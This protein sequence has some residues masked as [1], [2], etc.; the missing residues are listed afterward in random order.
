MALPEMRTAPIME[1]ATHG[2]SGEPFIDFASA[3]AHATR[4]VPVLP[5]GTRADEALAS[6]VGRRWDC[7]SHLVV[8][9]GERFLGVIPIESLVAAPGHRLLHGLID[10]RPPA[11][12]PGT[13]REVAAWTAMRRGE[14]ALA[15][16]DAEGRFVGLIPP[17]RL[18]AVGAA[19]H[20]EDLSR[21]G[22]FIHGAQDARHANDEPVMRRFRH[23][24][25]WVLV[26]LAGALFS[27]DLMSRFESQLQLNLA[28]AFFIPAIVYLAD[29]V[30]TQTETVVVRALSLGTTMRQLVVREWLT[31]FAV[32]A[33]V[34]CL[35]GPLV[36]LVW[37]DVRMAACIS[38]SLL[39]ACGTATTTGLALPWVL[40]QFEIDPAYG[41]GPL[42]TVIQDLASILIYF[43]VARLLYGAA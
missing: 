19:E 40:D 12:G 21:L 26:G 36:W 25:P 7:A 2:P 42:A 33:V 38:I 6:L 27:A 14:T 32:G 37:G 4:N 9:E 41:S 39:A 1:G 11:V 3:S 31:G 30:G 24:L 35:A 23:R 8:C 28:L 13:D 43:Q 29:A 20:E 17:H 5:P 18:M 34:A 22:G 10:P 16:V 15:V